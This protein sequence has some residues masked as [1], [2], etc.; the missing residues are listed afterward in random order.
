VV[1]LIDTRGADPMS[2]SE[3]HGIA[4][5]VARTFAALL[6]CPS[7][8]VA[9]VT[10]EGGSGGA[11]AMAVCDHVLAWEN[12]VFSVI[13]PEGAASIL[14]RDSSRGPELAERLGITAE[15]LAELDIVD[16]IIGEPPGGAQADPRVAAEDLAGHIAEAV[17]ALCSVRESRRLRAREHRWRHAGNSW[18]QRLPR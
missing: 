8:T 14:F 7:P 12:S 13:A 17:E 15:D 9:A 2:S 6:A 18:I 4:A 5:A 1:T 10:G 11:L 3:G 16:E